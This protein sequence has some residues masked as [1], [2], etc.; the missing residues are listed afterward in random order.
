MENLDVKEYLTQ[1]DILSSQ[2]KYEEAISYYSKAES[3]D[4]MNAEIYI[5]KGVAYANLGRNSEAK[6]QFEKALKINRSLGVAYFHLGSLA[7][8]EGDTALGMENYSK[9][10][11]NGFDDA[12]VYFCIGLLYEDEGNNDLA[13]RNYTKAITKD[14]LRPDIRIRKAQLLLNGGHIHEALQALDEMILTN[15][16]VFEGYHLKFTTLI[17]L[18][19][20]D[21]AEA[22]INLAM[23]LFPKD[24]AFILDKATLF[25]EQKKFDE[26]KKILDELE[27][28]FE[29]EDEVLHRVNVVRAQIYALNNEL[30]PAIDALEKARAISD[31]NG[32][33]DEDVA[34]LLSNCYLSA[35]DYEKV[36]NNSVEILKN[37]ES[38]YVKETAR[39][40]EPLAL[41]KLG[42]KDEALEKYKEAIR[43]YRNQSLKSP[44]N[45]DS[46]L[47]RAMCLRDI[48]Q[49]DKALE[50]INYVITLKPELTE[51]RMIKVTIFEASGRTEEAVKEKESVNAML[52]EE[53]R[54]P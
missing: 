39:Y 1:G 49:Y 23:A 22:T 52:P 20:Y 46:Y 25:I 9:A 7:I 53:L 26:A 31:K 30:K 24:P 45:L 4:K 54:I 16:D 51:P 35:G 14:A 27:S 19:Q 10:V 38:G 33:F 47:F 15:P 12:Q 41:S 11:S 2:E 40:Y 44:D 50:L 32:E 29:N 17:G 48:E 42:R 28:D 13:V 36:L 8:L 37:S 21:K 18:K 34:F 5:A 43:E 3:I 6:E